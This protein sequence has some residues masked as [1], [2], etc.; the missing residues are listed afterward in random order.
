MSD[1][2]DITKIQEQ[3]D[4]HAAG[5]DRSAKHMAANEAPEKKGSWTGQRAYLPKSGNC[6]DTTSL[7]NIEIFVLSFKKY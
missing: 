4:K 7:F 6:E 3:T 2:K 5:G 1:N